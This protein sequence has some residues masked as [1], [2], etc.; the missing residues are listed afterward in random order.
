MR[1]GDWK[2]H[3]PHEYLTV[4]GEPG[5]GGKPSNFGKLKPESIEMSGIRGIASRH[6]YRV[7]KIGQVLYNLKDDP[8]ETT[9][10]AASHPEVVERLL[11]VAEQAKA[12]LGDT[13]TK[14]PGKNIRP[15]GDVRPK[16]ADGV[17]RL[18]NLEYD[19]PNGL[20]VLLDLYRPAKLPA[21]PLPVV[22]WIHGGGWKNGSKE[23]VPLA[24]LAAEGFAVA[25]IDYRLMWES[26]WPAA[27]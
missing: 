11:A 16:L 21:E 9:D 23:N 13:L 25:T 8:G 20:A 18:T 26:K 17:A 15:S 10:V 5:H 7:E 2:L 24:W 27:D 6:G 4:A 22:V 19:R 12:D 3:L 1:F 14:T